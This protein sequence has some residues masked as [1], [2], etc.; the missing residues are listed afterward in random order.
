MTRKLGLYAVM[1]A[2]ASTGNTRLSNR[3]EYFELTDEEKE[4]L[5]SIAE[6]K[7]VERLKRKGI[8]EFWYEENVIY[9]LNQKNADRKAQNKGYKERK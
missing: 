6:K 2:M 7:R 5:K 9:A 3:R 8:K 1:L 4:R